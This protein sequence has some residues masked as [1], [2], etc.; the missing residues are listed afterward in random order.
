MFLLTLQNRLNSF[1]LNCFFSLKAK[2]T[3]AIVNFTGYGSGLVFW[4]KDSNEKS[5]AKS[6]KTTKKAFKIM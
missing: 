6:M 3:L 5:D 4:I 1:K 2:Q